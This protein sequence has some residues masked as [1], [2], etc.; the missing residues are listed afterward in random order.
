MLSGVS[1]T[2]KDKWCMRHQEWG[3]H[4]DKVGLRLLGAGRR[5]WGVLVYEVELLL[6]M[7]KSSG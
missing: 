5:L 3:S 7:M 4:T 2:Q 6:G 1:Q